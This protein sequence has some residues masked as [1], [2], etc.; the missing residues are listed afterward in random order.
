MVRSN[1]IP[2]EQEAKLRYNAQRLAYST[3]VQEYHTIFEEG[4]EYSYMT[5]GLTHI[6]LRVPQDEPTTLYY[7]FCD[8]HSEVDLAGDITSQLSKTSIARV[9]CFCLMAFRSPTRGQEWRNR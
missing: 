8:P 7:F 3:I 9:L 2:T 6:L 5:N 4:Y 1:K